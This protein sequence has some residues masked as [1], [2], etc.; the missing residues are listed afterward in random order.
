MQHLLRHIERQV[1]A[2]YLDRENDKVNI[3]EKIQIDMPDIEDDW[4]V[5][6]GES[7]ANLCDISPA[8]NLYRGFAVGAIERRLAPSPYRRRCT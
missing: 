8:V 2:G 3:I 1:G 5:A 7:D 4:R 6:P